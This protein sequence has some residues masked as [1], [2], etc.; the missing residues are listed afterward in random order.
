MQVPCSKAEGRAGQGLGLKRSAWRAASRRVPCGPGACRRQGVRQA[1][2]SPQ[3]LL[4]VRTHCIGRPAR[5]ETRCAPSSLRSNSRRE[6]DHEARLAARG[7]SPCAS[8]EPPDSPQAL[9]SPSLG[10]AGSTAACGSRVPPSLLQGCGWALAAANIETPE[11]RSF[12]DRAPPGALRDLTH[13]DCSSAT[14]AVSEASFA[15]GRRS[16]AVRHGRARVPADS[17]SPGARPG[18]CK[19]QGRRG[20]AAQRRATARF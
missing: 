7:R 3:G 14:N 17:C 20:R 10:L 13:R 9:P 8:R 18:A 15:V 4:I 12:F 1:I 19:R 6:S 5:G 2:R 16:D 11:K